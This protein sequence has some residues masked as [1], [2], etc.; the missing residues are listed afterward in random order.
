MAGDSAGA[1]L[2]VA[3]ALK[4]IDYGIR[5]PDGIVSAYGPFLIR[6]SVSPSR[7]LS[8]MDPLLHHGILIKCLGAY[9]GQERPVEG[10]DAENDFLET[11]TSVDPPISDVLSEVALNE[12]T[13]VFDDD[14]SG[15]SSGK[16][17]DVTD[18][19]DQADS[20]RPQENDFEVVQDDSVPE[21][22]SCA[23]FQE[24]FTYQAS[25]HISNAHLTV[26]NGWMKV[27]SM[28][29]GT[30]EGAAGDNEVNS[31][32]HSP[33]HDEHRRRSAPPLGMKQQSPV[34][35]QPMRHWKSEDLLQKSQGL[36]P[37]CHPRITSNP[38]MSPLLASDELLSQLPPIYLIVSQLQLFS[39]VVFSLLCIGCPFG[40][41]LG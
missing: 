1:N 34:T 40:S 5:L 20:A 15:E 36:L 31:Q 8:V 4:A 10:S 9:A 39:N 2:S 22:A 14:E 12:A 41:S 33:V 11:S 25:V 13:E 17:G 21:G 35:A 16:E 7:L 26:S 24:S 6:Y 30:V 38:Y 37:F 28:V 27:K 3:V 32:V 19:R 29:A 18:S 23:T